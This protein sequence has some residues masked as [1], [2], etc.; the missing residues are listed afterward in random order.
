MVVLYELAG[1]H[2]TNQAMSASVIYDLFMQTDN[3][4]EQLANVVLYGR[5]FR[6]SSILVSLGPFVYLCKLKSGNI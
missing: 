3:L 6:K 4:P 2:F 1:G 5:E